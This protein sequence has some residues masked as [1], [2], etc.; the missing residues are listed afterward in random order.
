MLDE[1][2]QDVERAAAK[3]YHAA[4][5]LQTP[6]CRAET[7]GTETYRAAHRGWVIVRF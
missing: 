6:R 3:L 4:V 5:S 2:D 1:H 7:V